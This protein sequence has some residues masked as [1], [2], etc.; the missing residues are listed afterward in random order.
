MWHTVQFK[1]KQPHN[2]L[3]TYFFAELHRPWLTNNTHSFD[4]SFLMI[5]VFDNSVLSSYWIHKTTNWIA[6]FKNLG[7]NNKR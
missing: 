2:V 5:F 7:S 6:E 3:E 4:K 1:S